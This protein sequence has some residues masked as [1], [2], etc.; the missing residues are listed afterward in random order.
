MRKL[1][2]VSAVLVALLAVW[3]GGIFL[4]FPG[5]VYDGA[6]F[7]NRWRAGLRPA[8]V[9]VDG[10][11]WAY[12]VGG[13]G[14]PLVLV[15]GFGADKDHFGPLLGAL[16]S[17]YRLIVPDLPGFGESS[18]KASLAYDIPSQV[19]RF[20]GF[21]HALGLEDFH[22]AGASMGG[23]L[24]AYYAADHPDKVKSLLLMAPAGVLPPTFGKLQQIYEREGR[25]L[26]LY[27]SLPE[28]DDFMRLIF[29]RPPWL[30]TPIKRHLVERHSQAHAL[31]LKILTDLV[32]GG[33]GLLEG[34]LEQIACPTLVIWGREDQV[35]PV[36][37]LA[38]F[39]AEIPRN[40]GEIIDNCGHVPYLEKRVQTISLYRDFMGSVN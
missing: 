29:Y 1:L 38:R 16:S 19:D 18:R 23:Y 13:Q 31:L 26:L 7:L 39:V 3:L 10:V 17:R 20:E 24:A 22:L 27:R 33:M 2:K 12:L 9:T 15:H 8:V 5:W 37:S 25:I 21:I 36:A 14:E 34:R 32:N 11:D 4:F 35:L 30:P 6:V 40:R 28:F